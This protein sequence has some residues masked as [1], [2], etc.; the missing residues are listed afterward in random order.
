MITRRLPAPGPTALPGAVFAAISKSP[1]LPVL[2]RHRAAVAN[3]APW[4]QDPGLDSE[5]RKAL[6]EELQVLGR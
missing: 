3:I 6:K 2:F 5:D 4:D 1:C